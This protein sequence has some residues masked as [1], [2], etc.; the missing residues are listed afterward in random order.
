MLF[1]GLFES[2]AVKKSRPLSVN[3]KT[4]IQRMR[5]VFILPSI[6]TLAHSLLDLCEDLLVQDTLIKMFNFS[7]SSTSVIS[8]PDARYK[9]ALM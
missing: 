9:Y 4:H 8:C 7:Q 5:F 2:N 1:V 3:L 6:S